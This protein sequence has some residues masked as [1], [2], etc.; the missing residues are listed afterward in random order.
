MIVMVVKVLLMAL[1]PVSSG[2]VKRRESNEG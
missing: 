1:S 2:S